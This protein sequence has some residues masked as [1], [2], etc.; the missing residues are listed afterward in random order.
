MALSISGD[1]LLGL[2][3]VDERP[4]QLRACMDEVRIVQ[5]RK[6]EGFDR[7]R[8]LAFRPQHL[9][10]RGMR[11]CT[12]GLELERSQD[13]M[14]G[15]GEPCLL[16]VL[17]A[18]AGEAVAGGRPCIVNQG[19]KMV[20]LDAHRLLEVG[21]RLGVPFGTDLLG[22]EGAAEH[23]VVPG[24]GPRRQRAP[25]FGPQQLG[26]KRPANERSRP[27]LSAGLSRPIVERPDPDLAHA[28]GLDQLDTEVHIFALAAREAAH[29]VAH[30][31]VAA[32]RLRIGE[33]ILDGAGRS[34]VGIEPARRAPHARSDL[35]R[36]GGEA[37]S[38]SSP[39]GLTGSTAMTAWPSW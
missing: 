19:E 39:S 37:A 27:G 6:L 30:P 11:V 36:Q 5:Q 29:D 12:L 38:V 31:E 32:D 16:F 2:A 3:D 4:P 17:G 26:G 15:L 23:G 25:H 35:I 24:A 33:P 22:H 8:V 10:M 13:R 28:V 20:R 14:L 21:N 7:L 18:P 1:R 9:P 34:D